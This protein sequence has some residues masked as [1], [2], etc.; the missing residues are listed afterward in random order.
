MTVPPETRASAFFVSVATML[1]LGV[2]SSLRTGDAPPGPAA[3]GGGPA[4]CWVVDG[5]VAD[6]LVPESAA[7]AA[8]VPARTPPAMTPAASN[9]AARALLPSALGMDIGLTSSGGPGDRLEEHPRSL[10]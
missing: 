8:S 2:V 3:P 1:S 10:R 7:L 6:V 4:N 5:V 9:P